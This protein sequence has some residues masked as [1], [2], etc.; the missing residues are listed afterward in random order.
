[1]FCILVT[2]I[3]MGICAFSSSKFVKRFEFPK[4]LYKFPIII[5]II[6]YYYYYYSGNGF[7]KQTQS[8]PDPFTMTCFSKFSRYFL[9]AS[10]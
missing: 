4:A 2:G 10:V 1:M 5:I 9:T 3:I 6:I 7:S 8:P